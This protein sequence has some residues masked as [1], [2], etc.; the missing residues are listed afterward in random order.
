LI[1]SP[2]FNRAVHR[3]HGRLTGRDVPRD[4]SELGGTSLEGQ[5]ESKTRRFL[6]FYVEEFKKE[7]GNKR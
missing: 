4:Y 2:T 1:A 5:D 3:I 6:R 7:L